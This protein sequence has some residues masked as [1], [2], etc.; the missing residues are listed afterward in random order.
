MR[1]LQ[2]QPK[3]IL[4]ECGQHDARQS[5]EVAKRCIRRLVLGPGWQRGPHAARA[6]AAQPQQRLSASASN[7]AQ[8][9][10]AAST[11]A[12]EPAAQPSAAAE[13]L[14]PALAPE[15]TQ[16]L[17]TAGSVYVG[18]GFR[19]RQDVTAF[20]LVS[21]GDVIAE[22][23]TVGC[24]SELVLQKSKVSPSVSGSED[25]QQQ[26]TNRTAKALA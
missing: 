10:A 9:S 15:P 24:V 5:V 14:S 12:A 25:V 26:G 4:V 19:W 22:V 2:G 16:A 3:S 6:A 13:S 21:R 1:W 20:Q 8:G 18:S 17:R 11:S 7:Y 23:G